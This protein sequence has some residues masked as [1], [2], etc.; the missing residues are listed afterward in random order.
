MNEDNHTRPERIN[1]GPTESALLFKRFQE[2]CHNNENKDEFNA[3]ETRA[4]SRTTV[5]ADVKV[6]NHSLL[7]RPMLL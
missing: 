6:I 4:R 5:A 7:A 3:F 2:N 1:L